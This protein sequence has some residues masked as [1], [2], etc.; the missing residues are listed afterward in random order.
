M[1]T[2]KN[3]FIVFLLNAIFCVF[4]FVGGFLTASVS[5]LSDA[6]HDLGD[7]TTLGLSYFFEKKSKNKPDDKYTFGYARFSTLASAITTLVLILGSILVIYTSIERIVNPVIINHHNI[8]LFGLELIV[9]IPTI[10]S[11]AGEQII[12]TVGNL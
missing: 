1:K 3:I 12:P 9:S 8:Y 11:G 2:E 5:I 4:E 7:A 10:P 6:V